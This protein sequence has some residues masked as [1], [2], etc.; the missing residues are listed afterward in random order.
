MCS[1]CEICN[2]TLLN[3]N[4]TK[5]NQSKQHK[6]YSNLILNQYVINNVDVQK[7]KDIFD[8]YYT[9]HSRK[10]I[11][12][13]LCITLRY[14]PNLSHPTDNKDLL[15][16]K[17]KISNIV[18]Y[19]IHSQ[20]YTTF[21]SESASDFLYRDIGIYFPYGYI[22]SNIEILFISDLKNITKEHYLELSKSMLERKLNRKVYEK[23]AQESEYNWLP[24][25][26]NTCE[27]VL[28]SK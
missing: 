14:N 13:N 4:K 22:I 10:I 2:T 25:S 7:F 6:H 19:T 20:H 15:E 23:P 12:F 3:R 18:S 26:L 16:H 1:R 5:H 21:S 9:N 17:I 28:L 24:Y 27:L 8:P 11:Y